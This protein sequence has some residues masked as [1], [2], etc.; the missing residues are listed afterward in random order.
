MSDFLA[1]GQQ[2][3]FIQYFARQKVWVSYSPTVNGLGLYSIP[4]PRKYG[5]VTH[6][7]SMDKVYTVFLLLESMGELLT[8]SQRT[9]FI[10]HFPSQKAQ[11]SY[12]PTVNEYDKFIFKRCLFVCLQGLKCVVMLKLFLHKYLR[13]TQIYIHNDIFQV[14]GAMEE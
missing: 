4:L 10:Q 8:H 9:G 7:Q 6:P 13:N 2:T 11:V 5:R 12:S 1:H 3:G 14:E